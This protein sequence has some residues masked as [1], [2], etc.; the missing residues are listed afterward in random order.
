MELKT[1]ALDRLLE[2]LSPALAAELDRV[3]QETRETLEQ[4]FQKRLQAAVRE[5]E[6]STAA[7]AAIQSDRSVAEAKEATRKQVTEELEKRFNSKLAETREATQRQVT[8]ELERRFNSKLAETREATQRQVTEELEKQFSSK[9]SDT[10]AQLKGDA[11]AE[12]ARLQEQLDQW[13]TFAE[14]H[15]QLAEASSQPEILSRFL[16]LA[17]PFAAGLG[18]YV[19]KADG[20][21]LWKGR[22][23][24]AFPDI[25]S[26]ETTDPESYFRTITVRDKT[27]AAVCGVPPFK[28]E[29]LDFLSTSLQHAIEVF[30]LKLRAPVPGRLLPPKKRLLRLRHLPQAKPLLSLPPQSR[31]TKRLM[32]RRD[33]SRGCWCRKSSC[34]MN[35]N[36]KWGGNTRIFTNDCRRKSISVAKRILTEWLAP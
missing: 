32:R 22:G 21:A 25:I 26:R 19:A 30:G 14:T 31:T 9:L 16:K 12:R 24:G 15:A 8:E 36:S 13:R 29:A 20:L 18:L 1:Q 4:E 11:S 6:T 28:S 27:V 33:E 3:V 17:R 34:I 5:A 10:T 7:A 23:D 35:R 2:A